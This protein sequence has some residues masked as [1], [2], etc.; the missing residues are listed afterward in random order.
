MVIGCSASKIFASSQQST[1]NKSNNSPLHWSKSYSSEKSVGLSPT[2]DSLHKSIKSNFEISP[3]LSSENKSYKMKHRRKSSEKK[4]EKII[5]RHLLVWIPKD[6]SSSTSK[7]EKFFSK[8]GIVEEVKKSDKKGQYIVSFEDTECAEKVFEKRKLNYNGEDIEVEYCYPDK[9][10]TSSPALLS[11]I[12]T[13]GKANGYEV[14][15]SN[16][17]SKQNDHHSKSRVHRSTSHSP[18]IAESHRS[19]LK[20]KSH[21]KMPHSESIPSTSKL[22]GEPL[23]PTPPLQDCESFDIIKEKLNKD[24]IKLYDATPVLKNYKYADIF[25]H[26]ASRI[27]YVSFPHSTII[28]NEV[29]RQFLQFG[30]I[31]DIS[32]VKFPNNAYALIEYDSMRAVAEV[33]EFFNEYLNKKQSE[34]CKKYEPFKISLSKANWGRHLPTNILWLEF[35][36][37]GTTWKYLFSKLKESFKE[38]LIEVHFHGINREA[39]VVFDSDESAT[40]AFNA[41]K[42]CNVMF[43]PTNKEGFVRTACDYS[44]PK[45]LERFICCVNKLHNIIKED[46]DIV[47]GD[48]D[49][50]ITFN[51]IQETT[52]IT[53][54]TDSQQQQQQQL[55]QQQNVSIKTESYPISSEDEGT[56]NN[57][58]KELKCEKSLSVSPCITSSPLSS[59][60]D[61]ELNKKEKCKKI[62]STKSSNK[63]NEKKNEKSQNLLKRKLSKSNNDDND[64]KEHKKSIKKSKII[65]GA[66]PVSPVSRSS[67]D[68]SPKLYTSDSEES[69]IS[70]RSKHSISRHERKSRSKRREQRSSYDKHVSN[71]S[72]SNQYFGESSR[73]HYETSSS[74]SRR[75]RHYNDQHH[76]DF[77][78]YSRDYGNYKNCRDD[79]RSSYDRKESNDRSNYKDDRKYSRDDKSESHDK[80][81]NKSQDEK[82]KKR[83]RKSKKNKKQKQKE[84][85][86]HHTRDDSKELQDHKKSHEYTRSSSN[87]LNEKNLNN[88]NHDSTSN[89]LYD[90]IND[91]VTKSHSNTLKDDKR[92]PLNK[93]HHHEKDKCKENIKSDKIKL[94]LKK[95]GQTSIS[96]AEEISDT[97]EEEQNNKNNKEGTSKCDEKIDKILNEDENKIDKETE[98]NENTLINENQDIPLP[99]DGSPPISKDSENQSSTPTPS[100]IYYTDEVEPIHIHP[101]TA[102]RLLVDCM[103]IANNEE[104]EY[105]IPNFISPSSTS[106]SINECQY[107]IDDDSS[108]IEYIHEIPEHDVSEDLI[109]QEYTKIDTFEF[110]ETEIL[111][112]EV[113]IHDEF[114][115]L[116][117]KGKKIE[118][119][120]NYVELPPLS[121]VPEYHPSTECQKI[122]ESI[123]NELE[124]EYEYKINTYDVKLNSKGIKKVDM[125]PNSRYNEEEVSELLRGRES[126]YEGT[127]DNLDGI[128]EVEENEEE[129]CE[130][131]TEE[132]E[133]L[134][135]DGTKKMKMLPRFHPIKNKALAF[136]MYGKFIS[137]SS[138]YRQKF[139]TFMNTFSDL[140]EGEHDDINI[141]EDD[142]Y[143]DFSPSIYSFSKLYD[144]DSIMLSDEEEDNNIEDNK[145]IKDKIII[146]NEIN[147]IDNNNYEENND[148]KI[149]QNL[150]VD[151]FEEDIYSHI[152]MEEEYDINIYENKKINID[153]DYQIN[154]P[155][156]EISEKDQQ[157]IY[158][159]I[160]SGYD[161]EN[162]SN[163][164][165]NDELTDNI[166]ND[167]NLKKEINEI[168]ETVNLPLISEINDE[169]EDDNTSNSI[170]DFDKKPNYNIDTINIE[171]IY[172]SLIEEKPEEIIDKEKVL[173]NMSGSSNEKLTLIY[174][175]YFNS[176]QLNNI[177]GIENEKNEKCINKISSI[178][179]ASNNSMVG[180]LE[181][182]IEYRYIDD[183]NSFRNL[184]ENEYKK[185]YDDNNINCNNLEMDVDIIQ[186]NISSCGYLKNI[187]NQELENY[188]SGNEKHSLIT[189]H[190]RYYSNNIDKSYSNSNGQ[191]LSDIIIKSQSINNDKY[192]SYSSEE[193]GQE[194]CEYEKENSENYHDTE[195]Y[196]LTEHI[197]KNNQK[198][199]DK[200]NSINMIDEIEYE[201][202]DEELDDEEIINKDVEEFYDLTENDKS[203][204]QI[205][206]EDEIDILEDENRIENKIKKDNDIIVEEYNN[207]PNEQCNNIEDKEIKEEYDNNYID[208]NEECINKFKNV[209]NNECTDD[210][211][212]TKCIELSNETEINYNNYYGSEEDQDTDQYSQEEIIS[213]DDDNNI[214]SDDCYE[215]NFLP[216]I[217]GVHGPP[218]VIIS[219]VDVNI[220]LSLNTITDE[221]DDCRELEGIEVDTSFSFSNNENYT[222]V[223]DEDNTNSDNDDIGCDN[224]ENI[225][226]VEDE[227]LQIEDKEDENDS[228]EELDEKIASK[229]IEEINDVMD[230]KNLI[231]LLQNSFKRNY[232]GFDEDI[233]YNEPLYKR[234]KLEI[235]P[236]TYSELEIGDVTD[237]EGNKNES[238]LIKNHLIIE[239]CDSND[240]EDYE[241]DSVTSSELH[242][243]DLEYLSSED[244]IFKFDEQSIENSDIASDSTTTNDIL[245]ETSS[246]DDNSL[247]NLDHYDSQ[248]NLHSPSIND[249][250]INNLLI[251]N[252]NNEEYDAENNMEVNNIIYDSMLSK[253]LNIKN[254]INV[255]ENKIYT[256]IP[257]LAIF[258]TK[259]ANINDMKVIPNDKKCIKK[260]CIKTKL[261]DDDDNSLIIVY[262]N[263]EIY[264]ENFN[265]LEELK[266]S[267]FVVEDN[268]VINGNGLIRS[269]NDEDLP[270]YLARKE[271]AVVYNSTINNTS[272]L[273]TLN[274]NN[275]KDDNNI[276]NSKEDTLNNEAEKNEIKEKSNTIDNTNLIDK[277]NSNTYIP[278]SKKES[279]LEQMLIDEAPDKEAIEALNSLNYLD[280]REVIDE[281]IDDDTSFLLDDIEN[282]SDFSD[283]LRNELVEDKVEKIHCNDLSN[284][285]KKIKVECIEDNIDKNTLINGYIDKEKITLLQTNEIDNTIKEPEIDVEEIII[286]EEYI[287]EERNNDM[288]IV[289]DERIKENE[290]ENML[291]KFDD[292]NE[293]E[294]NE[295]EENELVEDTFTMKTDIHNS[296]LIQPLANNITENVL[297]LSLK[298][299]IPENEENIVEYNMENNE[300]SEKDECNGK[301]NIIIQQN[302]YTSLPLSNKANNYKLYVNTFGITFV[303]G[304]VLFELANANCLTSCPRI[305]LQLKKWLCKLNLFYISGMKEILNDFIVTHTHPNRLNPKNRN[306]I[307]SKKIVSKEYYENIMENLSNSSPYVLNL[308]CGASGYNKEDYEL[309][310]IRLNQILKYC[311]TNGLYS[312]LLCQNGVS[313]YV[314]FFIPSCQILDD[315]FK[316]AQPQA[317]WK[318][319]T[320]SMSYFYISIAPANLFR[321]GSS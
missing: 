110:D 94:S 17:E 289:V 57:V 249:P 231:C 224:L 193:N 129:I 84:K 315:Q 161:I 316:S 114:G 299:M 257:S 36:P 66:V 261:Q 294:T 273:L 108:N 112:P 4:E 47:I 283:S 152:Q 177:I 266:K 128:V 147:M 192:Y 313:D 151:I 148:E 210:E 125:N 159:N 281:T 189:N 197:Y 272:T 116:I 44:S 92:L 115:Y 134:N 103:N 287:Q 54:P 234:K 98:L 33:I 285:Q 319:K 55:L 113:E 15:E 260:Y 208:E 70:S 6:L 16:N 74:S 270:E 238:I 12:N 38:T 203:F 300:N 209:T 58:K 240:K 239:D 178:G 279:N 18:K 235:I 3:S 191:S 142:I 244:S 81:Q 165:N 194:I 107:I 24:V 187:N 291:K 83:D 77:G 65:G 268:E 314:A 71:T 304:T 166:N 218:K 106:D 144:I 86:K 26:S 91:K 219:N 169:I 63:D 96:G 306:I 104:K 247:I 292:R 278:V 175:Y 138:A 181:G 214:S 179:I 137:D 264:I 230:D 228:I 267:D 8:Y 60:E 258:T 205:N 305:C 23:S 153:D 126:K 22:I 122:Y 135:P 293:S 145:S 75:R 183:T 213:I 52:P 199:V 227:T 76:N 72:S 146:E 225:L 143:N 296:P 321:S 250:S 27:L 308:I 30:A 80:E 93:S 254:D 202:I 167:N 288:V 185:Y 121:P 262:E 105:T 130:E 48:D 310:E 10:Y 176:K 150:D 221:F 82:N 131:V 149:E 298:N 85:E 154:L 95:G 284:L 246:Y 282:P 222:N 280:E 109:K 123:K 39:V 5:T 45:N 156:N 317:F 248:N 56:E 2:S 111:P 79:Y 172:Q 99:P 301:E 49:N 118:R 188:L 9:S 157:D 61:C 186:D 184:P 229:N 206:E 88:K 141:H 160:F 1:H 158:N 13:N 226:E 275:D 28:D 100:S 190:E 259:D 124:N 204:N 252:E 139:V 21:N 290:K 43:N 212:I 309:E 241:N 42:Q 173:Q 78:R 162:D 269:R 41:F 25:C 62:C 255:S 34:I 277:E 307:I 198:M 140:F 51:L 253:D 318:V 64:Y 163:K 182:D 220:G 237:E 311:K 320:G 101:Y 40:N 265:H 136:K 132:I 31:L 211:V 276:I 97:D 73:T 53:S 46:N 170:S 243:S 67:K 217:L 32:V 37:S 233:L 180:I 119:T 271:R 201:E 196:L 242:T 256:E 295:D 11:E 236:G 174:P 155:N 90:S 117:Y 68:N 29:K 19:I 69:A 120:I 14:F 168:D 286:K 245:C 133:Q 302:G 20:V 297:S 171:D 274:D 251:D 35:L 312:G 7:I 127:L 87:K 89:N 59:M 50:L 207:C 164:F 102:D 216:N 232:D 303:N 200:L 223:D 195:H 263:Y 215:N